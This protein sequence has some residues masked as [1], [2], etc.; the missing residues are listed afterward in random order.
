MSE[1][2]PPFTPEVF[3]GQQ[4]KFPSGDADDPQSR[5][6]RAALAQVLAVPN[7]I[8]HQPHADLPIAE[9]VALELPEQSRAFV[10][11]K[12]R[13][14]YSPDLP[15]TDI[16]C[17]MS[18]PI[19]PMDFL[20]N[21]EKE[22]GQAWFDG[23]Q[24]ILDPR[25]NDG[26]D[27]FP[28]W[29][30]TFWKDMGS[31]WRAQWTWQTSV[32][33]VDGQ[34]Q[35]EDLAECDREALTVTKGLFE[36]MGW[37]TKIWGDWT[38]LDL[39]K[40]LSWQWLSDDHI[41]ML[42]TD[43]S[44]RVAADPELAKT[45]LV[46]PL[47]FSEALKRAANK[48]YTKEDAPLLARYE[49]HIKKYGFK[50]LYFPNHIN[51]NHWIAGRIDFDRKLIG[52][53]QLIFQR[54]S[55]P[56][57]ELITGTKR[58]AK[59][60]FGG[61]DF[62]YQGDSMDHGEQRD[63]S[64]CGII[65][66]NT[67]AAD[68]FCDEI[69]EQ[70]HAAG[71]RANCFIHLA[72]FIMADVRVRQK[73]PALAD[74]LNPTQT[75]P[76]PGSAEDCDMPDVATEQVVDGGDEATYTGDH[77]DV[78]NDED[79]MDV[80]D[81][82]A[83]GV[84]DSSM[85]T[86]AGKEETIRDADTSVP[87]KPPRTTLAGFFGVS[88]KPRVVPDGAKKK[89]AH[90]DLDESVDIDMVQPEK[91]VKNAN[92]TGT[93]KSSLATKK[94][95]DQLASGELTTQTADPVKYKRWQATLRKGD[96]KVEMGAVYEAARWNS[97]LKS[98][99]PVLHPENRK[100][101]GKGKQGLAGVVSLFRWTSKPGDGKTAPQRR[102][103][104][105]PTQ[106]CPGLTT[107]DSPYL[108]NYLQRTGAVGG[109]GR[110]VTAIAK[111]KFG[112]LFSALNNVKRKLVSDTQ[113]HEHQWRNDHANL[114]VFSIRCK[115]DVVAAAPGS[116]PL[117]CSECSSVLRLKKFK[118]A[119]RRPAPDDA[120]YIYVNDKYRNQL[121]GE[122]YARSIGLKEII[123][124]SDAK[125]TP[126]IKFAQGTLQGKYAEFEVFGGLVEAMVMKTDRLERGVGMRNFKYP[127]AW[128]EL[129]HI[130]QIHSPSAARALRKHFPTRTERSFRAKEAREPRFPMEIGNR[131]FEL[132]E[133]YLNTINYH[134]PVNLSCDDTKLFPA[135]RMYHDAKEK[136]DYLVGA[137]EGPIR[138]ADP[139]A[140]RRVLE[141]AKVIKATK[142]RVWCLSVPLP[143]ITP[144]VVAA[145]PIP[146]DM[147]A[148]ALLPPLEKIL[149]GLLTRN[150][151]VVSYACDGTEVERSV[152]RMLV[153]KAP[154]KIRHTIS[155]P[156][157]GA[158]D[159]QLL[160]GVFHGFPIVMIQDSK[161][162]LKTF[163]NNL[164][165]GARMLTFGNFTA[166]FRRI[167]EM[168]MSPDSPLYDRDVRRLDRQD[169]AAATRLFCAETLAYL[170]EHFPEY[171]GEIVYL[172]I[173][174]ELVD[175]YQNREISHAERIKM[176]LRARYFLDAW[177]Q[178][179]ETAGYK[180]SQYFL[181]REA[182]DIARILVEG[183]I[184]LIIVHRD[185]VPDNFPLLPWF[186]SSEPCEHT[187]GNARKIVK[188]FTMLEFI[189][190]IVKL[191]VTMREAVLAAKSSDPKA[192]AQGYS[193]TYYDNTGANLVN[194]A[195]YPSDAEIT[196]ISE[197]AAA[198]SDALI[199]L[200]GLVPGHLHR[201]QSA[202][203]PSI[204]AW[205][206]DDNESLISRD[207]EFD[208]LDGPSDAEELQALI[209]EQERAP[210]RSARMER[211]IMSLT[212]ASI[213]LTADEH[214]R[215]YA[216][217]LS[218]PQQYQQMDDE[219][220]DGI[221]GEEYVTLQDTMEHLSHP[222]SRPGT[223]VLP[224]VGLYTSANIV[225]FSSLIEQRR[226]HQ[227]KQAEKCTR[228][229]TT[230][231]VGAPDS[232]ESLRRQLLRKFHEILK[233]DHSR[234]AGSTVERQA[235]WGIS[236]TTGAGNAAN[237]AAVA[238]S[239]ASKVR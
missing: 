169:D 86:E 176:S 63:T 232:E 201:K 118:T 163:R 74:L 174:G 39:A 238:A 64:S 37:N 184:S 121:L 52:T 126:C 33:W 223:A 19:P 78:D 128:D 85:L 155:S 224:P 157:P 152:Q 21:L 218:Y 175:A 1:D 104:P 159:L 38:H 202:I 198:E 137:V 99:C 71:A 116:R 142:V 22:A 17:L 217:T 164:F 59:S 185:H 25:Y 189:F 120:N 212:C 76:G 8:T 89:R 160:I 65:T 83:T 213:A 138:V 42:M 226:Q 141:D 117:P 46:A 130:I 113:Y 145:M 197:L 45:V 48:N 102:G 23:C 4:K 82:D 9:F 234:A 119:I 195:V 188:D 230:R 16:A 158:P 92:G 228:T 36:T 43:L 187:F 139:E 28:L 66:P 7:D 186:H 127:P 239:V 122:I 24:S 180:P 50:R 40:I 211:D 68:I 56:P 70:E 115:T 149:D 222:A 167:Y 194:L 31:L 88:A 79:A 191:R 208:D 177:A 106:P 237:A 215:V 170:S 112:K 94:S 5:G 15:T 72:E 199:S 168:A 27:R 143:G 60:Q 30:V 196:A 26:C 12:P 2:P 93:S 80:E 233:E 108:L 34:L 67:I 3:I 206:T 183:L 96:P 62:T 193:H 20:A 225:D 148:D 235:R 181:S 135:L 57:S 10:L 227:T 179:L 200:L 109:G 151:R 100:R 13:A 182:V 236:P 32:G 53:G 144:L 131:N 207:E 84:E 14:W 162:A 97:H 123:E 54:R 229:K 111:E 219:L 190:M 101:K 75:M 110:S 49:A 73:G 90:A 11:T 91:R 221:L 210:L 166:V 77:G 154:T 192:R 216:L 58:W 6:A 125:N 171:I 203:L 134:G 51:K 156:I 81:E 107:A 147:K 18:R 41:D 105:R 129:S 47:A 209:D 69:W 61:K 205:Y 35:K 231:S 98:K 124:T 29:V 214:M 44:S 173:F 103:S 95:R 153:E 55:R 132:A 146:N 140:M 136:V 114:R 178:F 204:G 165:T 161:H 220:T 87:T 133:Q 172:F 150:I